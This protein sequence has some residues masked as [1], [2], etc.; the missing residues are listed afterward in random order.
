MIAFMTIQVPSDLLIEPLTLKSQVLKFFKTEIDGGAFRTNDVPIINFIG[1]RENLYPENDQLEI[2]NERWYLRNGKL[3]AFGIFAILF[4]GLI[5]AGILLLLGRQ[6][7]TKSDE[8][9]EYEEPENKFKEVD[10]YDNAD[11]INEMSIVL[12]RASSDGIE[13]IDKS[14]GVPNNS[15]FDERIEKTQSEVMNPL[16][17]DLCDTMS[18]QDGKSFPTNDVSSGFPGICVDAWMDDMTGEVSE[19]ARESCNGRYQQ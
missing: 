10:K 15:L 7:M 16:V 1:I 8:E 14:I 12:T 17:G 6:V 5:T 2:T 13:I 3:S 11:G 4:F 18:E 9:E 19:F